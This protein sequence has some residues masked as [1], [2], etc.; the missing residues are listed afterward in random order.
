MIESRLSLAA[1]SSYI[2]QTATTMV[3]KIVIPQERTYTLELPEEFIGKE[4]EVLAFEVSE[5]VPAHKKTL[6]DQSREARIEYL[7]KVLEPYRVDLSNFTFDRDEA[8]DYD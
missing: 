6:S 1:Y 4:V 5:D 7:R 3:R 8:N 2:S